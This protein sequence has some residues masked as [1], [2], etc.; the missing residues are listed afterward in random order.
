M[1]EDMSLA[2]CYAKAVRHLLPRHDNPFVG[3]VIRTYLDHGLISNA[4]TVEAKMISGFA[5]SLIRSSW[6]E[7]EGWAEHK[8][9]AALAVSAATKGDTEV[10]LGDA[11]QALVYAELTA[12]PPTQEEFQRVYDEKKKWL[13]QHCASISQ[14]EQLVMIFTT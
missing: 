3:D 5:L 7:R 12:L 8:V 9:K 13:I 4:L 14:P 10:T 2:R 1:S 11:A 6:V